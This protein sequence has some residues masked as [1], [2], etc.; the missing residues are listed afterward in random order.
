MGIFC[1]IICLGGKLMDI[2]KDE[3]QIAELIK[4]FDDNYLYKIKMYGLAFVHNQKYNEDD[5]FYENYETYTF[6]FSSHDKK[7]QLSLC[8]DFRL[9]T[10]EVNFYQV[11]NFSIPKDA[12]K[13]YLWND[14]PIKHYVGYRIENNVSDKDEIISNILEHSELFFDDHDLLIISNAFI[15]DIENLEL[16]TI[17]FN[18]KECNEKEFIEKL[19][20]NYEISR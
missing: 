11:D 14:L 18:H 6:Y 1:V 3:Q 17:K 12:I 8:K 15:L 16:I 5:L 20:V 4:L 2:I 10:S 9:E 19:N 7:Y 13:Y